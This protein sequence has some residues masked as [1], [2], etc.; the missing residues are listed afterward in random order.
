MPKHTALALGIVFLLAGIV[1]ILFGEL[2]I[3][4]ALVVVSAAFDTMFAFA[5]RREHEDAA[6]RSGSR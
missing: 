6:S 3:G 1:L 5:L 2:A 4:I